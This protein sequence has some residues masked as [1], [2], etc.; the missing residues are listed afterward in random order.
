MKQMPLK[1]E[2]RAAVDEVLGEPEQLRI[3][4]SIKQTSLD[5]AL[6]L[7]K[8]LTPCGEWSYCTRPYDEKL[9]PETVPSSVAAVEFTWST[10][11]GDFSNKLMRYCRFT[12][13]DLSDAILDNCNFQTFSSVNHDAHSTKQ[14]SRTVMPKE[15]HGAKFINSSFSVSMDLSGK[16]FTDCDFTNA[17]LVD[18]N[19]RGSELS[20]VFEGTN[21][22]YADL[23]EAK[24]KNCRFVGVDFRDAQLERADF[25]GSV[26]INC[27]LPQPIAHLG[28]TTSGKQE[29]GEVH[30]SEAGAQSGALSSSTELLRERDWAEVVFGE[31]P[32]SEAGLASA[33]EVLMP[34]EG[35]LYTLVRKQNST[36]QHAHVLYGVKVSE[37]ELALCY[38]DNE[39]AIN[40]IFIQGLAIVDLVNSKVHLVDSYDQNSS[41]PVEFVREIVTDIDV[42]I[43]SHRDEYDKIDRNKGHMLMT[44][45]VAGIGGDKQKSEVEP[46]GGIVLKDSNS[47]EFFPQVLGLLRGHTASQASELLLENQELLSEI[48]LIHGMKVVE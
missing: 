40:G 48:A 43:R 8:S 14:F 6:A 12:S 5:A 31:L 23:T 10:L 35:V 38:V 22:R 17:Y 32:Y 42:V 33:L 18:V 47:H 16:R 9:T 11:T 3:D 20:G 41:G 44:K 36:P 7:V 26:F 24:L 25:T 4:S 39:T 2:A 19:L 15:I 45:A 27:K 13:S 37:E 46:I 1:V 29:A 30:E 34:E 28:V 21:F